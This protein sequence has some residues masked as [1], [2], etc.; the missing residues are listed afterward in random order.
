ML[1]SI[2]DTCDFVLVIHYTGVSSFRTDSSVNSNSW[3]VTPKALAHSAYTASIILTAS[4]KSCFLTCLWGALCWLCLLDSFGENDFKFRLVKEDHRSL[5]TEALTRVI[6]FC[7]SV[8]VDGKLLD[9]WEQ[10]FCLAYVLVA[11]L[12]SE[13]GVD[14]SR[15]GGQAQGW[16]RQLG[17]C[18]K[19][20]DAGALH[21]A[22]CNENEDGS[23][24][25]WC[26]VEAEQTE[27][28]NTDFLWGGEWGGKEERKVL[29]GEMF[30]FFF[31]ALSNVWKCEMKKIR[32]CFFFSKPP[33]NISSILELFLELGD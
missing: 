10:Q 12:V 25:W 30:I 2:K 20:R 29:L 15:A 3:W 1:N 31:K 14:Q 7:C 26:L 4:S 5:K 24:D 18:L 32:K 27:P 6:C 11:S 17:P 19:S 13:W 21:W 33:I 28:C 22:P 8:H 9:G 23:G 16:V